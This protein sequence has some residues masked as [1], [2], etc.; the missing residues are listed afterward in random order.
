MPGLKST[1]SVQDPRAAGR[2]NPLISSNSQ[3]QF[4]DGTWVAMETISFVSCTIV[5]ISKSFPSWRRTPLPDNDSCSHWARQDG[6]C[7]LSP[8]Q[9]EQGVSP[10]GA[11]FGS[12]TALSWGVHSTVGIPAGGTAKTTQ[13][14]THPSPLLT[15]ALKVKQTGS[16]PQETGITVCSQT[17]RGLQCPI[18]FNSQHTQRF[19]PI[20]IW[21]PLP[22]GQTHRRWRSDVGLGTPGYSFCLY[23]DFP[24]NLGKSHSVSSVSFSTWTGQWH[25]PPTSVLNL[26]V[27]T[28]KWEWQTSLSAER[29]IILLLSAH[30]LKNGSI[31]FLHL[32]CSLP[33]RFYSYLKLALENPI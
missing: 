31:D 3:E 32:I 27:E 4:P 9:L 26:L 19:T 23:T 8:E 14:C 16:V 18:S 6:L 2:T 1:G 17:L 29:K 30:I 12:V 13:R 22:R 7:S 20:S 33:S 21:P 28:A 5:Y 11:G 24:H 25:P 15:A 10:P